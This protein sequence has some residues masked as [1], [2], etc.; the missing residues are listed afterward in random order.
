[1]EMSFIDMSAKDFINHI[2]K[3]QNVEDILQLGKEQRDKG[4]IYERLWDIVIKLGHC[5]KFP[6]SKFIHKIGNVDD[7]SLKNLENLNSYL[8]N[9]KVYS[10]NKGGKSDITLYNK[11][12]DKYIFISSKF[13][14]I[15]SDDGIIKNKSIDKYGI[16]DII[17]MASKN[18]HLYK[19]YDIYLV[20]NNRNLVLEKSSNANK[21][22]KF[23][24]EEIK[25]ENILDLYDLNKCFLSL[26]E[27]IL[28]NLDINPE[29]NYNELYL[30]PKDKLDLR[31]HQE[32]ITTKTSSLIEEGKK[33]FL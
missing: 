5:S 28:K 10:G 24:T 27:D 33:C 15:V 7:C 8:N 30:S 26:K 16:S 3:F 2:I 25:E 6:N 29:L 13:Y 4:F 22:N 9:E 32:F 21:S 19:K 17:A 31:F 14:Q 20:V 18:I 23:I 12:D 1:M 11:E